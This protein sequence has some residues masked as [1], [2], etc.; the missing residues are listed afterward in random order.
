MFLR[1]RARESQGALACRGAQ[2]N[3][4]GSLAHGEAG[5][6]TIFIRDDHIAVLRE[7]SQLREMLSDVLA[8]VA[9]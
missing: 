3:D 9:T 4:A 6:R 7:G 2:L 8:I 1:E 5:G